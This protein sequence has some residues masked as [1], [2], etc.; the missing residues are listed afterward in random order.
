MSNEGKPGLRHELSAAQMAM[1]G[2]GGSIGTGL[3]LSSGRAIQIAGPA[4]IISFILGAI[5]TYFVAMA[6]GEL[7][8]THPDAGSFGLYAELYV[9]D[10]AGFLARYGYWFSVVTAMGGELVAS[11]TYMGFWF[12]A[13]KGIV[14]VVF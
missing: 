8:S 13:V 9:N 6:F 5:I 7:A 14:W 1:V 10:W 2:V 4:V 12:P 3:F 11:A